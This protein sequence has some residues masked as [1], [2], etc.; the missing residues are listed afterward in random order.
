M[1]T[2][3][4]TQVGGILLEVDGFKKPTLLA[5]KIGAVV[6]D[7]ARVHLSDYTIVSPKLLNIFNFFFFKILYIHTLIFFYHNIILIG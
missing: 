4:K 6:G 3:R 2:T 1:L 7:M 5:E